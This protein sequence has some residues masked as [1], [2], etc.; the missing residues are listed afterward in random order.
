MSSKMDK[1]DVAWI[2]MAMHVLAAYID[3]V[4]AQEIELDQFAPHQTNLITFSVSNDMVIQL[5]WLE[6]QNFVSIIP[7]NCYVYK[8]LNIYYYVNSPYLMWC[9][10]V[11]ISTLV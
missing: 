6:P 9:E 8:V 1:Q 7:F 2:D 4:L 10:M 5:S 11:G 3:I